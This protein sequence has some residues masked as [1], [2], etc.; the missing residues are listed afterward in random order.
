MYAA[1]SLDLSI[2]T[3]CAMSSASA[4]LTLTTEAGS[5]SLEPLQE[6]KNI[7]FHVEHFNNKA[8][9]TEEP[10]ACGTS[11]PGDEPLQKCLALPAMNSATCAPEHWRAD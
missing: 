7:C 3:H 9:Q 5:E 6:N 11:G 10:A 2:F 1:V 4:F 8:E